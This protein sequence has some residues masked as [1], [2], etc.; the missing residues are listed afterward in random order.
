MSDI[1]ENPRLLGEYLLF[2]YGSAEEILPQSRQ[3]GPQGATDFPVRTV[4]ALTDTSQP[5]GR[6]LDLGCATGRSA[7]ELSRFCAEVVAIDFS[8]QFITA[9]ETIRTT[10]AL[11]YSVQEEGIF[12]RDY[13]ARVPEGTHA[14]RVSF[15]TGDAMNLPADLGSFDLVHAANL[16]CRLPD[17]MQL[18]AR[19]PSLVRPGGELLLATPFSWLEEFT[20]RSRWPQQASRDWLEQALAPHFRLVRALDLPF[21]IREHARK[22]QWGISLGSAWVRTQA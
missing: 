21:L 17:P 11:A 9:A 19:L 5:R 10:G 7:F 22:Y 15:R 16:L 4:S 20:P 2:H 14:D 3:D 8:S 1:Y 6:A 13:T 12:S 18:I